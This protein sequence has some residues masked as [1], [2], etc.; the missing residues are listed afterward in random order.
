[1]LYKA[2]KL[3]GKKADGTIRSGR[4]EGERLNGTG[5]R[6]VLDGTVSRTRK[7]TPAI[8]KRDASASLISNACR[9]SAIASELAWKMCAIKTRGKKENEWIL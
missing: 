8:E 9:W 4:K 7:A 3:D 5:Q 2:H 6:L 1:M